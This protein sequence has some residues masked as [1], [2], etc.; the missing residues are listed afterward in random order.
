MQFKLSYELVKSK[1]PLDHVPKL[2]TDPLILKTHTIILICIQIK[3][4]LL[5][6]TSLDNSI[7]ADVP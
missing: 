7:C 4:L 3:K 2:W 6:Y 5:T 1:W